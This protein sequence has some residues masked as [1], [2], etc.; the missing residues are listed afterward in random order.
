MRRVPA[1]P[2]P[3]AA[4]RGAAL[5]CALATGFASATVTLAANGDCGQPVTNGSGPT[6]V[7]CSAVLKSAVGSSVCELCVCDVNGSNS[8]NTTDALVCLKI[9]VGQ[10]VDLDCP[11]CGDL[12]TTTVEQGTGES[13]T[14][15]STTSTTT[16]I[17][18]RCTS[19][20][21]CSGLPE[22]FRCNP[23]TETCEKPCTRNADCHDFYLCNKTTKYCEEPT[24]LF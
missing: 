10:N 18:V 24:Q 21:D 22:E 2:T 20:G 11:P 7:D 6:A 9:A 12:T 8:L 5:A 19:E 13:T 1:R 3:G 16:T 23:N 15:T 4:L 17:P 14:S